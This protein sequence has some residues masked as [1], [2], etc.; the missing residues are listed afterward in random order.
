[1]M[2]NKEASDL[3]KKSE[4]LN[5]EVQHLKHQQNNILCDNKNLINEVNIRRK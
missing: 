4:K 2:N 3:K 5:T 1:M